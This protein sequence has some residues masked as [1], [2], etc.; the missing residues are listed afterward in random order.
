MDFDLDGDLDIAAISYFP[1]YPAP[2]GPEESFVYLENR[3]N[4]D[5]KASTV[6][7]HADGRWITMDA[8]DLD[9]DG[10]A[11]IVLGSL[12]LGPP[13]IPI[14]T[15]IRERWKSN[16]PAVLFLENTAK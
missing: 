2:A 12:V 8:G 5:F 10:D 1:D 7:E 9:G 3:G 16:A 4:F 13:G 6:P 14:P 11:D 15:T